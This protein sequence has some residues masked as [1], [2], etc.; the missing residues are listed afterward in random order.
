MNVMTKVSSIAR[1]SGDP[2][3]LSAGANAR[4][5]ADRLARALGWFSIGLGAL[6]LMAPGSLSRALG[7]EGRGK[8]AM[9]RAFGAREIA[10]GVLSLSIDAKPGIASR[11]AGD[12]LDIAALLSA[13]RAD[14]PKQRNVDLALAAVMTVT[15]VDIL[16]MRGLRA[17]HNR[18]RDEWRDYSDRSGLPRGVEA[19][20]GLA[21]EGAGGAA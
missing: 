21:R 10:A 9:I 8:S 3:V 11:V 19:S 4:G 18:P 15:M 7:M 1:S 2:E 17:S 5:G 12:A 16:C 20:R 13:R 14:N 6:E